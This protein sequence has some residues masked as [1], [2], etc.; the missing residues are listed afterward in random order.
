MGSGHDAHL[1]DAWYWPA[2]LL[3]DLLG[4]PSVDVLPFPIGMPMFERSLSIPNEVAYVPQIGIDYTNIMVS[5][6]LS[7]ANAVSVADLCLPKWRRTASLASAAPKSTRVVH[8]AAK[9]WH[10][11]N[12]A[13]TSTSSSLPRSTWMAYT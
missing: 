6:H 11:T 8:C 2:D 1:K 13:N 3:Q 10:P 4:V 12:V 9:Y 7:L 5:P